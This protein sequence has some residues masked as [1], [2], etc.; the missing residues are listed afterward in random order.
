[1]DKIKN[2]LVSII[3]NCFNGEKYLVQALESILNQTYKN[4]EVIFWDNQSTD[5]SKKIFLKFNDER[6]KYYLSESHTP[7]YEARNKAIGKCKGEIIAFL[8]TDDWWRN[9]KLE[10]QISFFEKKEVGLVYSNLY[11]FFE[12]TQKEKIY[13]R[14][15]LKSGYITKNLLKNYN[16]GIST[17]LL[18]KEAYNSVNGF[19]NKFNVI[20]DFDLIVRLS[21]KWKFDCLQEPLSY[22]RI[23]NKN[24]ILI[25]DTLEIEELDKWV[26]S[27]QI[28]KNSNLNLYLKYI[29]RRII[30]LKTIKNINDGNLIQAAKDIFFF[31]ICYNKLKLILHIILPKKFLKK[32]KNFH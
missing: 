22:Y 25:N 8:D 18:R 20:G 10:K 31:P 19:N 14:K 5:N 11:L 21:L 16:I 23:H 12:Q 13:S 3:V 9:N 24:F 29:K 6:F 27:E 4:W 28:I 7:L 17:V 2:P 15:I 1:M 32:V 30:F 26:S